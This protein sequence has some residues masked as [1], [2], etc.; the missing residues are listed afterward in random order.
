MLIPPSYFFDSAYREAWGLPP[1]HGHALPRQRP[2]GQPP[3]RRG[4][5]RWALMLA[6]GLEWLA[7]RL[8]RRYAGFAEPEAVPMAM[9]AEC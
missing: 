1:G 4:G 3:S 5:R 6:S 7:A 2:A 9:P 8:R